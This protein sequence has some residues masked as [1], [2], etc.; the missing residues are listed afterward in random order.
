MITNLESRPA[1][2]VERRV[3]M[4]RREA[5]GTIIDCLKGEEAVISSTGLI[6]RELFSVKD[7]EE[8]FY[9]T[10]SLGLASSIGL[11]LALC[12]PE[13]RIIIIEGDAALLMNLGSLTTI[14][15]FEP[16][17]LIHIV[18]DNEAY[19]SCSEER[20]VSSTADLG[21]LADVAGYRYMRKVWQ[22][23]ELAEVMREA[24]EIDGPSFILTKIALGGERNLPRPLDLPSITSRF[25]NFLQLGITEE[26]IGKEGDYIK[27]TEDR[28]TLM[29]NLKA[30][31]KQIAVASLDVDNFSGLGVVL[32]DSNTLPGGIRM[33]IRG[34]QPE[35]GGLFL[36]E[37]DSLNFL[38]ELTKHNSPYHDGFVF[39]NERGQ[40][41]HV[42]Q[43]FVPP[44]VPEIIPNETAG[45]RYHT[46]LFGSYLNGV[47]ATGVVSG[48]NRLAHCFINGKPYLIE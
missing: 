12:R 17:N 18:L 26:G 42:S 35:L 28:E 47:I 1:S 41:T 31:L 7:S 6:S 37:Q 4:N 15:H 8:M 32:Y 2:E 27:E 13:K 30:L 23:E 38:I 21:R 45:V 46:A 5:I 14:G 22:P 29:D 19:A 9:M 40:L 3:S 20:S 36:T 34:K 16:K 48:S 25:R 39:I 43:Y 10:G 24:L 11:G 33:A 44:I